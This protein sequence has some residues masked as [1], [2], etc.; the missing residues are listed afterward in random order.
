MVLLDKRPL[1][2]RAVLNGC[3]RFAPDVFSSPRWN[4]SPIICL[5]WFRHCLLLELGALPERIR[6][7]RD[8]RAGWYL[9]DDD[10]AVGLP[11]SSSSG[12][13]KPHFYPSP[14]VTQRPTG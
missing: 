11:P 2:V 6:S 12:E 13:I 1:Q 3:R 14:S 8:S 4:A 5:Y 10:A 7:R 9:L